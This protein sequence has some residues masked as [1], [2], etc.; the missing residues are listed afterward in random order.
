MPDALFARL[1][2]IIERHREAQIA[3]LQQLVRARSANPF[4][5]DTSDP[6]APIER[7]IAYLIQDKLREIGLMPELK[8]ISPERP[9][10]IA[11]LRGTGSG[12]A[13]IFN[14]HMD[15][16]MPSPLWTLDPFGGDIRAG[17]LYGLGALDM[18]ASLS[19]FVFAAKALIEAGAALAGDLILTF[20]VDEEPGGCSPF[21]SAYLL[22]NGLTG[23]AAIVAEPETGNVTIGH[24]GGYRFRLITHGEATHTG[25]LAWERGEQGHNAIM[26]MAQA[27]TALQELAIP[28]IQTPAFPDRRPVFTFPTMIQG[29]VS[30]N[31]VPDRCVAYGDTR[32]LPGCDA[33]TLERLMRARLDTL[34]GLRYTLERLLSVPAVEIAPDA[35]IVNLLARHTADITGRTPTRLGCGPWNDG[36]M[37]ITRGIPAV[38]GFGP[39]GAGVHGPD[40]Y[41][42]LDSLI[43]VTRIYARAA[44]EFLGMTKS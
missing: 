4:V 35:E 39:D 15:T 43:A 29:G 1:D 30:I 37:F 13:L 10:V 22:D 40:E 24:R 11:T 14:G 20:V 42:D 18:K 44:V 27:I 2:T 41:V 28:F 32:L 19:A 31:A 25:L 8:G 21:G 23:T 38:C 36:W 17:R 34:P 5:P 3:F 6:H 26:A 33:D 9:N 7:D 16:V 12:R